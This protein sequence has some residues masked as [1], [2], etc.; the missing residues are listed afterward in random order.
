MFLNLRKVF[1]RTY[2]TKSSPKTRVVSKTPFITCKVSKFD[3]YL[4]TVVP[5]DAKFGSIPLASAGWQHHKSK[6]DHFTIHPI[7]TPPEPERLFTEMAV[8]QKIIENLNIRLD[9]TNPSEIQYNAFEPIYN[10]NHTLIAAETGCGKT[11]AYLIPIVQNVLALKEK[12]PN[13]EM[14]SPLVVIVT[15]GRELAS[16]IGSVATSLCSGLNI[17]VKTVVGGR[18]KRLIM[19][20]HFET[21]DILVGSMGGLSK[22]V[23]TQIYRMKNVRHVVI[24]EADTMLDDSFSDKLI[25]FLKR[26][27]FHRNCLQD[28][29]DNIVGTQLVLA[30]AT[31]P[32]NSN[33]MLQQVID[34]T[35]VSKVVSPNLHRILPN[36]TQ[37][38][39]RMSKMHRPIQM[40]SIVKKELSKTRPVIIFSNKSSTSDYVSIFL[41]EHDIA[42]VN[43]NG[44]MVMQ[45]RLGQFEKFQTGQV[46][47]ISTTDVV[48]RGLNTIRARHIINFD[49]PLHISDYIHRIGR[50]GRI[51]SH[52]KCQVTN[53]VSG[54]RELHVVQK[55]EHTARTAAVLPN[56]NANITNIIAERIIKEI[57]R[58]DTEFLKR[59]S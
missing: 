24:E 10:N 38:F 2:A 29:D 35:T 19:N 28:F 48:S 56:V 4:E 59:S 1:L 44:D 25:Y 36:V 8:D 57:E 55:I 14:N 49:F 33:E 12:K 11:L 16:Q 47:V 17:N 37:N 52:E 31:M 42:N 39:L 32:N 54:F 58:D 53:F 22:L 51:G 40:L 15:P 21:I 30:S 50:I 18:T 23:T 5:K 46:H 27:P 3:Q 6:G 7:P 26:F 13:D 43:L 9:A 45:L 20:P 41:E 34:P